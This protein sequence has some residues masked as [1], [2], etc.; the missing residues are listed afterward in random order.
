[1]HELNSTE[2]FEQTT[3]WITRIDNTELLG[4]TMLIVRINIDESFEQILITYTNKQQHIIELN[5]T[6]L[7]E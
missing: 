2:L 1:M 3:N 6:E 7:F 5:N 4:Q